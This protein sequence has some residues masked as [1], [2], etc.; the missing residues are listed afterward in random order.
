[1]FPGAASCGGAS[2]PPASRGGPL[3]DGRATP[4]HSRWNLFTFADGDPG[5]LRGLQATG[6]HPDPLVERTVA[7]TIASGD[8][9]TLIG[10]RHGVSTR[11]LAV[12]NSLDP[13]RR[14]KPGQ[15][16]QV[17]ARHIVP[18][19]L[20]DGIVVNVPQRM[21]FLFR[22]GRLADAYPVAVGRRDWPTPSGAFTVT[23]RE[24]DK[25]W[26]V[27]RSIQDE[28]R[29]AGEPVL[30]RVIEPGAEPATEPVTASVAAPI[31]PPAIAPSFARRHRKS[32]IAPSA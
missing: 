13:R 2:G 22:G 20:I 25:T 12:D 5:R 27:P 15:V 4:A 14:L 19:P 21:L 8:S 10:A 30:E 9:L 17:E 1:M 28:M 7:H 31:T 24:V 16:L 6:P 32:P 18:P 29:S 26:I 3:S 11:L 23:S